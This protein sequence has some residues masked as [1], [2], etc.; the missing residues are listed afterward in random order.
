MNFHFKKEN[1]THLAGR[2]AWSPTGKDELRWQTIPRKTAI[3][4]YKH[5]F[6]D[7][8]LFKLLLEICF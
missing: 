3:E 1:I 8:G 6:V 5:Y 7:F 4:I 2:Y